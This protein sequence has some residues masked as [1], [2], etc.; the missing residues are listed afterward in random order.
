[1]TDAVQRLCEV[2]RPPEES[3][4]LAEMGGTNRRIHVSVDALFE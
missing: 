4:D 2:T 3:M 1:L